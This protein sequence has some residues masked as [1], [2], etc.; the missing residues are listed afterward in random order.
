MSYKLNKGTERLKNRIF[1]SEKGK[2]REI[3]GRKVTGLKLRKF[4]QDGRAAEDRGGLKKPF[5]AEKGF[6]D[7]TRAL[8]ASCFNSTAA[9]V[10]WSLTG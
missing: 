9:G 3:A 4:N 1:C 8:V 10:I 2:P 7:L 5:S 6:F